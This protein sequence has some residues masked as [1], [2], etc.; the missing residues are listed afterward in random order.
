MGSKQKSPAK[1]F[2]PSKTQVN[3]QI[4]FKRLAINEFVLFTKRFTLDSVSE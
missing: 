3:Q 4:E 2:K 1:S